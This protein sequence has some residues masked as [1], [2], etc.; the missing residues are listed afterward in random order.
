M[1]NN[2]KTQSTN[3]FPIDPNIQF[4]YL[5]LKLYGF[6]LDLGDLWPNF[7]TENRVR[8]L[9]NFTKHF[10]IQTWQKGNYV[11]LVECSKMEL[12]IRTTSSTT[13]NQWI[14]Y[15]IPFSLVNG[16]IYIIY[17]KEV[18]YLFAGIRFS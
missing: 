16:I 15:V 1:N 13:T 3:L 14:N 18:V 6:Y 9:K 17:G 4:K 7:G 5:Y 11:E 12:K 10:E 2:W 8:G